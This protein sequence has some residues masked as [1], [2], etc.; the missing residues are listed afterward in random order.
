MACVQECVS[1]PSLHLTQHWT[2]RFSYLQQCRR[3]NSDMKVDCYKMKDLDSIPYR[4]TELFPFPCVPTASVKHPASCGMVPKS[5]PPRD[6]HWQPTCI[7]FDNAYEKSIYIISEN[8]VFTSKKSQ[9][10]PVIKTS[11]LF[12]FKEIRALYYENHTNTACGY[13]VEVLNVK[14]SGTY[15]GYRASNGWKF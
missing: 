13:N 15:N 3:D 4:V 8:S 5:F 12:L 10:C 14:G 9:L 2:F 6:T 11:W 1:I 7:K